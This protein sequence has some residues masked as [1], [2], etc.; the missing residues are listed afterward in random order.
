MNLG[1]YEPDNIYKGDCIELM[2]DKCG[3]YLDITAS[4]WY[5]II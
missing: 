2:K 4:I 1:P 3:Y 5:I